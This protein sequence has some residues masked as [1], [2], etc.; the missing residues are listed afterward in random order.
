MGPKSELGS[1]LRFCDSQ[2]FAA[3]VFLDD[4]RRQLVGGCVGAQLPSSRIVP[5]ADGLIPVISDSTFMLAPICS[6]ITLVGLL[7]KLEDLVRASQS[8]N[9]PISF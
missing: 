7:R 2:S 9:K 4:L 1:G 8:V 3:P 6:P 5:R